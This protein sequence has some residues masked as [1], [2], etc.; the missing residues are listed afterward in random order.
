MICFR[1]LLLSKYFFK[2]GL[3]HFLVLLSENDNINKVLYLDS[4]KLNIKQ[5]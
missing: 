4:I 2:L 1:L 3:Y 5:I